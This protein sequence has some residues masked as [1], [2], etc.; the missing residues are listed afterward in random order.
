MTAA[1]LPEM[2][3]GAVR[4]T[5]G[6]SAS[7]ATRIVSTVDIARPAEEVFAFVTAPVH[8]PRW[9]PAS[10]AAEGGDGRSLGVGE[11]AVEVFRVMGRRGKATWRVLAC[12]PGRRWRIAAVTP[13]GDAIITYRCQPNGAGT[14]FMRTL[15]YR[16]RGRGWEWVDRLFGAR[17][18]ARQSAQALANLKAVLEAGSAA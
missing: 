13:E 14:R 2:A 8:W 4:S 16:V 12:E 11:E 6:R 3:A 5:R 18:M 1:I 7:G 15:E 10:L 17:Y 9:H